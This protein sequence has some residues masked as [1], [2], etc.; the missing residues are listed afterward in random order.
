MSLWRLRILLLIL[1]AVIEFSLGFSCANLGFDQAILS[2]KIQI[3]Y[4]FQENCQKDYDRG[5]LK[6]MM[7]SRPKSCP[8][9]KGNHDAAPST[10]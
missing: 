4:K 1:V 6:G 10:R 7:E 9:P 5:Y 3:D 2:G 8:F